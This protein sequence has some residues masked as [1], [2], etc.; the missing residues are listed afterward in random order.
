LCDLTTNGSARQRQNWGHL[1]T[2]RQADHLQRDLLHH[3]ANRL[4]GSQLSTSTA[5][6]TTE[7]GGETSKHVEKRQEAD[8]DDGDVVDLD[9]I[10]ID[11]NSH[12][13]KP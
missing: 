8:G 13:L 4:L 12:R 6:S 1:P 3:P 2:S 9:E 10:Q 5:G 7:A 11:I